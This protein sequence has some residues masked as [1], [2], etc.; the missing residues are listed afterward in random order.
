M[1][2]DR[3]RPLALVTGPTSGIGRA[4]A[5]G[6]AGKGC[7]LMLVSKDESRLW[8]LATDLS[9][10][11]RAIAE[12]L[13]ADLSRG[14]DLRMVEERVRRADGLRFVVNNA[15]FLTAD[16]F[17]DSD[18]DEQEA[19][20]HVH[21]AAAVRLTHAALSV[22]LAGQR[23]PSAI[24][25]VSSVAAFGSSPRNVNYCAT[26]AYLNTFTNGLAQELRGTN[27][28]VQALCPGYTRTEI[29]G[30]AGVEPLG[31]SEDWWLTPE[32]VVADSFRALAAGRVVCIPGLRYRAVVALSRFV[33]PSTQSWVKE[34]V[35]RMVQGRQSTEFVDR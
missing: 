7:D 17:A 12:V 10:R 5:H 13:P 32:Q 33:S 6:L 2:D 14:D 4:F 19:M 24:V 31:V 16:E 25:N 21:V 1:T 22:M 3:L 27:V 28:R 8:E 30:R 18:L 15:G 20:V 11:H 23:P 29:H 34:L 26:K 35:R 9:E